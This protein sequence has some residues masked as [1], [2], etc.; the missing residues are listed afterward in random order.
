V[1][2]GL[3]DH[4]VSAIPLIG[5]AGIWKPKMLT[6]SGRLALRAAKKALQELADELLA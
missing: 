4:L 1:D 3:D 5:A 6:P 2:G